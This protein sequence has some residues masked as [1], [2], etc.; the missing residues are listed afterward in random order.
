M[1]PY[2]LNSHD[3]LIEPLKEPQK[4]TYLGTW[5]LRES[6]EQDLEPLGKSRQGGE[7]VRLL[8]CRAQGGHPS[9]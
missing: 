2:T 6:P 7:V 5:T 4:G 3:T 8:E 9:E 1:D